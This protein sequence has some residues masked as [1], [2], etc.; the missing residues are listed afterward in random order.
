MKATCHPGETIREDCLPAMNVTYRRAAARTGIRL[1]RLSDILNCRAA[2]TQEEAEALS[3]YVK[4]D[5]SA[6]PDEIRGTAD[7]F[8][9]MQ[10][11]YYADLN[12]GFSQH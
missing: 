7:M 2:M 1:K 8:M 10:Q 6:T 5:L 4:K 11:D 9:R 12:G 3:A